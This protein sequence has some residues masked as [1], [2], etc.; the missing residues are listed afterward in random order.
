[1][2]LMVSA[3]RI[4]LLTQCW[5]VISTESEPFTRGWEEMLDNSDGNSFQYSGTGTWSA[6]PSVQSLSHLPGVREEMLDILIHDGALKQS[7]QGSTW[8]IRYRELRDDI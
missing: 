1:M 2:K 5:C 3:S 8:D 4:K 6:A 7:A